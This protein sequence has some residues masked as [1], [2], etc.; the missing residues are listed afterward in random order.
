MKL[1]SRKNLLIEADDE[2]NNIRKSIKKENINEGFWDIIKSLQGKSF[3]PI[4]SDE[5][6][7]REEAE[8][9]REREERIKNSPYGKPPYAKRW[10]EKVYDPDISYFD[11]EEMRKKDPT[12]PKVDPRVI[13]RF[14]TEFDMGPALKWLYFSEDFGSYENRLKKLGTPESREKLYPGYWPN[15]MEKLPDDIMTILNDKQKYG[16]LIKDIIF[17]LTKLIP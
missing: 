6:V 7:A 9:E 8:R 4:K 5:D 3:F 11:Y 1:S 15:L 16:S 14:K 13:G 2:L 12:L 17:L 10:G